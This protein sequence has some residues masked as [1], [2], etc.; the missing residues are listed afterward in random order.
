LHLEKNLAENEIKPVGKPKFAY[1]DIS[2]GLYMEK[3]K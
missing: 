1:F 3:L 2:K